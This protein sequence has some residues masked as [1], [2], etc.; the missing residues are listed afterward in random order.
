M[1]GH[2]GFFGGGHG[3]SPAAFAEVFQLGGAI[4]QLVTKYDLCLVGDLPEAQVSQLAGS[5]TQRDLQCQATAPEIKEPSS[6]LRE[7][8]LSAWK[9]SMAASG[10]CPSSVLAVNAP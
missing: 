10:S 8:V 1:Q 7:R 3:A 9:M 4:D 2:C 5:Y 6:T